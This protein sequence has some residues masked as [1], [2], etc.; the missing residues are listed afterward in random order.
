MRKRL[1]ALFSALLVTACGGTSEPLARTIVFKHGKVPGEHRLLR[2]L[3]DRFEA[4]SGVRVMDETLPSSSDVQHQYFIT[5]LEGGAT[6]LD[7]LAMD[8]IWVP[9]FSRAG[10][11]HS[12]TQMTS[13]IGRAHV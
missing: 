12:G 6:A 5:T 11:L 7:V 3:L 13:K 4:E 2:D 10:W 1:S 8:V 9:E